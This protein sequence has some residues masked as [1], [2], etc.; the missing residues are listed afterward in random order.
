MAEDGYT[1]VYRT[2]DPAIGELVAELFAREGIDARFRRVSAALIGAGPQIFETRVDVASE[3][4]PRARELLADLEYVGASEQDPDPPTPTNLRRPMLA[5]VAFLVPGGGHFYARRVWTGLV[6]ATAI[7]CTYF[8]ATSCAAQGRTSK[9]ELGFGVFVALFLCDAIGGVLACRAEN[10]DVP[11]P[12]QSD[13]IL[14]GLVLT[15][16]ALG[17]GAAFAGVAST[18][19][20]LLARRLARF[21]VMATP[22]TL[23]VRNDDQDGRVV[24]ISSLKVWVGD[25]SLG[26]LYRAGGDGS[27]TVEAGQQATLRIDVDAI[28]D[29][30]AGAPI[31]GRAVSH[32]RQLDASTGDICTLVFELDATLSKDGSMLEGAGACPL[33]WSVGDPGAACEIVSRQPESA[34]RG[35]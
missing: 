7:V 29:L 28:A 12:G 21:Q 1:T 14:R 33:S 8:A 3:L 26:R 24:A 6:M 2:T 23:T 27:L 34:R 15:L 4:E 5:G 35:E 19:G 20:R 25:S 9:G 22:S 18:P 13:Q 17:A 31:A 10:R 11:R 16:I 32:E 30:C